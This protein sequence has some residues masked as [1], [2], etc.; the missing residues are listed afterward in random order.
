MTK[1]TI[2]TDIYAQLIHL[3]TLSDTYHHYITLNQQKPAEQTA[4][5]I[6]TYLQAYYHKAQSLVETHPSF[7]TQRY[8]DLLAKLIL[9]PLVIL[10]TGN[11]NVMIKT[12]QKPIHHLL[13]LLTSHSIID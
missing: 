3:I 6:T 1:Q 4:N 10:N 8:C 7:I 5:D 9:H 2:E 12:W 11:T 13:F